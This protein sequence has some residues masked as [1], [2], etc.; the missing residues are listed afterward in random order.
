MNEAFPRGYYLEGGLFFDTRAGWKSAII[1]GE[2]EIPTL[3][4]VIRQMEADWA[5]NCLIMY[6]QTDKH[7]I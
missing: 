2:V 1:C 5:I 6:I 3:F 7:M 4:M